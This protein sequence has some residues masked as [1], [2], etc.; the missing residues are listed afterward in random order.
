[1]SQ[2]KKKTLDE[3]LK[4]AIFNPEINELSVIGLD[5][6]YSL[7]A[8]H[9]M[10]DAVVRTAQAQL[11]TSISLIGVCVFFPPAGPILGPLANTLAVESITDIAMELLMRGN[12]AFNRAAFVKAKLISYAVSA[13]TAGLTALAHCTDIIQKVK[14]RP[15]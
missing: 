12:A 6:M 4:K 9:D 15:I 2:I 5:T 3:R 7:R 11:A 8:V 10:P 14:S 13:F 1:M